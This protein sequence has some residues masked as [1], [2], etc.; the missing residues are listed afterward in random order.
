MIIK[1]CGMREPE[2]IRE[3]AELKPDYVGFIF[4]P[5][6]KRFFGSPDPAVLDPLG[7]DIKRTGVFVN[8]TME[9]IAAA[10]NRYRLDAVQLHGDESPEFCSSLIKFLDNMQRGKTELIKAFGITAGFDFSMLTEYDSYADY[11]LFDT[12]TASYG[13]SGEP[14]NW[15]L[16]ANYTGT[17][18]FFLSGGLSP[19]NTGAIRALEQ[20]ALYGVDLNSRFETGPGIK[21]IAKLKLVFEE[22]K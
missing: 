3:L 1:V 13:G 2:N 16:L 4:Y 10:V 6:S 19:E 15:K 22:L 18:P 9:N 12:R 17:K 8:E 20:P 5:H 14:F 21:D 11:F 7:P